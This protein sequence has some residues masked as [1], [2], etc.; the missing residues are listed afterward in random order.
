[1]NTTT[2]L[3]Q[4]FFLP[5]PTG[6]RFCLF[7]PAQGA[8][9]GQL[10][11]LHP[12]AEELNCSRRVVAQQ[13]RALAGAGYAVL[14]IDL[15]GC[16]DSAGAFSDATW[17]AWLQDARL[18]RHWLQRHAQGPLWLWGLRAGALLAGA[19]AAE[20]DDP[21]HLLLWQP[22]G[23]GAQQLGQFLRLQQASQWLGSRTAGAA[24]PQQQLALGQAVEIAGYTLSPTLAQG[25][26]RARLLPP[27]P[28]AGARL[29]WLE[30]SPPNSAQGACLSP[31]ATQQLAAWRQAGWTVTAQAVCASSFWQTASTQ[32][33]PA[34]LH[35]SL[36]ALAATA[37]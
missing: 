24:T 23:S 32:D 35:A 27:P 14:Q 13:A 28:G 33:A 19:L 31:G 25:L 12:W 4:A 8:A 29:V 30:I 11:Y 1:M 9:R 37:P 10:L 26:E 3:P 17:P 22:V 36:Q 18:A 2:A 5:T 34:L 21:C 16:G 7:Y 20:S 6:E 15:L